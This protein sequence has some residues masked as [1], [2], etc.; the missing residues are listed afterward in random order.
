[1]SSGYSP[2][3][4]S[5]YIDPSE[6]RSVPRR[7]SAP[8][9]PPRN[10]HTASEFDALPE[11]RTFNAIGDRTIEEDI[12]ASE[13]IL[14]TE[15]RIRRP[16]GNSAPPYVRQQDPLLEAH[17]DEIPLERIAR[18]EAELLAIDNERIRRKK[19]IAEMLLIRRRRES[20]EED[21]EEVARDLARRQRALSRNEKEP[22]P[23]DG[24]N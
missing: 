19:E 4:E 10:F 18:E 3:S 14:P 20:K 17:V 2:R 13:D 16:R 5:P 21:D 22:T 12:Y 11:I 24:T 15:R 1:L 6:I 9:V 23:E 7:R 8:P